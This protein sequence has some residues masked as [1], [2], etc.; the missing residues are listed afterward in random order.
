MNRGDPLGNDAFFWGGWI[1]KQQCKYMNIYILVIF[2]H[3]IFIFDCQCNTCLFLDFLASELG[4]KAV[5]LCFF[6]RESHFFVKIGYK[7]ST[8]RSK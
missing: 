5:F 2:F 1:T 6:L 4:R 8:Y 7:T 3:E